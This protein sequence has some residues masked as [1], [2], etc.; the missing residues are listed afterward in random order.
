[1]RLSIYQSI[2]Q[3][4]YL[5]IYQSIYQPTN[6]PVNQPTRFRTT[7]LLKT[8]TIISCSDGRHKVQVNGTRGCINLALNLRLG[9]LLA[10]PV[11]KERAS[12]LPPP[13]QPFPPA[14]FRFLFEVPLSENLYRGAVLQ[15][16]FC[17]SDHILEL[18]L[19]RSLRR[20]LNNGA[21][22]RRH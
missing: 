14:L 8:L 16:R 6:Q 11:H 18:L 10:V 15:R 17:K 3:S 22:V 2:N 7:P 12:K 19:V 1:M 13:L 4:I 20:H 5:S 9:L 21:S